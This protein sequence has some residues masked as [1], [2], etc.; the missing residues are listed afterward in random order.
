M[1]LGGAKW[2]AEEGRRGGAR[3]GA[4]GGREGVVSGGVQAF[5]LGLHVRLDRLDRMELFATAERHVANVDLFLGKGVG[6]GGVGLGLGGV[7]RLT[8]R[9]GVSI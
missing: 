1:G 5:H 2:V 4:R 8:S 7:V 6:G 9:I 3:G